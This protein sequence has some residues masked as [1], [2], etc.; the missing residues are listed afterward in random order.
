MIYVDSSVVLAELFSESNRPPASFWERGDLVSSVL[1]EYECWVRVHAYDRAATHG[2]ALAD[3]LA[4]LDLLHLNEAT[5]ARCR[6]AFPIR[7][8]T[9]DALHLSAADF[10]RT[11]GFVPEISTYDERFRQ[12]A[13]ALG[14]PVTAF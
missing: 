5:C 4:R 3:L 9:L 6:A 12:A 13:Q 8:R 7:I 10:L 14:F 2:P 11:R 1:C